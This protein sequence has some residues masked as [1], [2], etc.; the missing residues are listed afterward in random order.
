[1]NTWTIIVICVCTF[2]VL[3]SIGAVCVYYA[4]KRAVK[5]LREKRSK[6]KNYV[7]K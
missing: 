7:E 2:A 4:K 3:E 5:K 1:M 6:N